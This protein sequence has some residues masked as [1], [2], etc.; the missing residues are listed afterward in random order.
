MSYKHELY[1]FRCDSCIN[2]IY[3]CDPEAIY[4]CYL[5]GGLFDYEEYENYCGIYTESSEIIQ[6]FIQR[7]L[8]LPKKLP[9]LWKIAEYYTANKYNPNKLTEEDIYKLC[10]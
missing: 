6:R 8:L 9:I 7:K 2:N 5:C 3:A 4:R 1:N 10:I